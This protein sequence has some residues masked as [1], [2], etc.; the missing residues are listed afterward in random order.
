MPVQMYRNNQPGPTVLAIDPKGT[1]DVMWQGH[2]DP[3]GEDIQPVS[4]VMQGSTAFQRAVRRG[5]V[6]LVEADDLAT[7]EALDRQQ[8]SF[9][10]RMA[11]GGA[12]AAAAIEHTTNNDMVT[13][14]CVGPSNRGQGQC[15]ADVTVRDAQKNE[16]PPLCNLHG[17]LAPQFVPQEDVVGGKTVKT[18][19]RVTMGERERY[20]P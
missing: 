15:G 20:Q 10:Q 7:I 2:G 4:E 17:D 19:T 5:V 11:A 9:D 16:R 18:W 14:P 1:D 3:N 6:S 12:Q 13:L 8:A